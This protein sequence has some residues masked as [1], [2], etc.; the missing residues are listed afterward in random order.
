MLAFQPSRLTQIGL[1]D[2]TCQIHQQRDTGKQSGAIKAIVLLSAFRTPV[3]CNSKEEPV[4]SRTSNYKAA[5][6]QYTGKVWDL[7]YSYCTKGYK[8]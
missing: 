2:A 7:L 6:V 5:L 3:L 1:D 4:Y 8:Q